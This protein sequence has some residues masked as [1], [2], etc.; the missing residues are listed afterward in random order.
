MRKILVIV[1]LLLT[2]IVTAQIN[3]PAISISKQELHDAYLMKYKKNKT[4]GWVLLGSGIGMILGGGITYASYAAQGFNGKAPVAAETL[5]IFI[6]PAVSLV[7]I[8]FFISAKRNKTKANLA[9]NMETLAP[10]NQ[11]F[12]QSNTM[13]LAL[14]I[15]L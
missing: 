7:S 11:K 5:F 2:Q 12:H 9:F 3:D 4:S 14:K 6:G 10:E 1:F 15:Q 8:P 13:A